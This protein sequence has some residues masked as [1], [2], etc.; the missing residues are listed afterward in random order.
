[1]TSSRI[2]NKN[3][4]TQCCK[5]CQPNVVKFD[6]LERP[7]RGC[8]MKTT[9]IGVWEVRQGVKAI[10][11]RVIAGERLQL[12]YRGQVKAELTK[13]RCNRNSKYY[14]ECD[15]ANTERFRSQISTYLKAL[16][17]NPNHPGFIL[18][19]YGNPWG[20]LRRSAR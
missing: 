13:I 5:V 12:L 4:L 11:D 16:E 17:E 20:L 18:C 19:H 8:F 9:R 10:R 15:R 7:M 1:M 2:D 6:R 3:T 14:P